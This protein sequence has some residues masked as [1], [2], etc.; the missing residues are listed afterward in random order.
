[1][2]APG[3]S[4]RAYQSPSGCSFI[5][6]SISEPHLLQLFIIRAYQS[7]SG[8]SFSSSDLIR[9]PSIAAF[10]H[11]SISEPQRLQ[12]FIIRCYQSP[13]YCSF[14]SSERISHSRNSVL[15]G[16]RASGLFKGCIALS[17]S[18]EGCITTNNSRKHAFYNDRKN[19]IH[20]GYRQSWLWFLGANR[21]VCH[22]CCRW[23]QRVW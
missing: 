6:M 22:I 1:M 20:R 12:L 2:R 14:S 7:P 4:F 5:I 16:F 17:D 3:C 9:A 23:I 18:S 11:Q 21:N 19:R 13:I 10:H 15:F 8:Y